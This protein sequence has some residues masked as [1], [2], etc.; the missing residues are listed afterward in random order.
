MQYPLQFPCYRYYLDTIA[1]SYVGHD[2]GNSAKSCVAIFIDH[3]QHD[4]EQRV[5]SV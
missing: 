3:P 5:K 1:Q 4:A 2:T